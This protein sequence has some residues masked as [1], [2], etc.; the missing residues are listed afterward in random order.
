MPNYLHSDADRMR[1]AVALV[2]LKFKPPDQSC[3]SY[4]LHLQS[5]FPPSEPAAPTSDGSWRNHALALEKELARVKAE[6]DVERIKTVAPPPQAPPVADATHSAAPTSQPKRKPK[7]KAGSDTKIEPPTRVDLQA[8]LESHP[9][10]VALP[11][12]STLFSALSA[13]E[14]VIIAVNASDNALDP[15]AEQ[16]ALVCS[17][18][19]RAISSLAAVLHPLLRSPVLPSAAILQT[20]STLTHHL[21]SHAFPVLCRH[22]PRKT[23]RPAPASSHTHE[24]IDALILSIFHPAIESLIPLCR[25][26]LKSLFSSKSTSA[27]QPLPLPAADPRPDLLH[28]FQSAFSPLSPLAP[29]ESRDLRAALALKSVCE[30]EKLFPDGLSANPGTW[31]SH[32]A[33]VD[34]LARRDALWYLCA[35]LHILFAPKSEPGS[36]PAPGAGASSSSSS[37]ASSSTQSAARAAFD[38][39]GEDRIADGLSRV[40]ARCRAGGTATSA[41]NSAPAAQQG[42]NSDRA[43]DDGLPGVADREVVVDEVGYEMLLGVAERYWLWIS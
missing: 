4:V 23:G 35:V 40:L 26:Y 18:S 8:V 42:I 36:V 14:R 41:C 15:T 20:L 29:G 10:I 37:C 13:F 33:R 1:I 34:S 3:A 17:I 9:D 16:R 30:L 24:L 19:L 31:T 5:I 6:L 11:H 2:A 43:A 32:D 7:K 39:A 38:G 28:L 12:S 27:K 22:K 21:V 25:C